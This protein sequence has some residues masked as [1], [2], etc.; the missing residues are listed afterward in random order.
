MGLSKRRRP[1]EALKDGRY[2]VPDAVGFYQAD[3]P[4]FTRQYQKDKEC[5]ES[6]PLKKGGLRGI[7]K[8]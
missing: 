2:C 3:T 6:P 4:H 7:F 1:V 8:R 5:F